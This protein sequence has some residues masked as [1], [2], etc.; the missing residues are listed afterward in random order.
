M[1]RCCLL[2]FLALAF[3]G[4]SGSPP[5]PAAAKAVKLPTEVEKSPE[6]ALPK[7]LVPRAMR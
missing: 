3:C 1:R 2:A 7:H 4:C 5:P 6:E